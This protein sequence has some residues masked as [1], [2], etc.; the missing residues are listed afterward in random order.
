M[1]VEVG[2]RGF[3]SASV[4]VALSEGRFR[5]DMTSLL[6]KT[7]PLLS[8]TAASARLS[9]PRFNSLPSRFR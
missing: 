6:H 7:N 1:K 9:H 8:T 5:I 2:M 3:A 4:A